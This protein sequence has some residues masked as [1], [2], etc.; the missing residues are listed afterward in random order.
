MPRD[1]TL[2]AILTPKERG[3][4]IES[5]DGAKTPQFQKLTGG[6]VLSG[7]PQ[8]VAGPCT[9]AP[10]QSLPERIAAIDDEDGA[11]DEGAGVAGEQ[12]RDGRDL[13][14]GRIAL[15]GNFVAPIM[16]I[17]VVFRVGDFSLH[18]ARRDGVDSHSLARPFG[19]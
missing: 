14:W 10:R 17:I 5:G 4:C 11:G 6:S 13:V 7:N 2:F 9:N 19:G 15:H 18:V 12:E 3:A 1:C 8:P 16:T